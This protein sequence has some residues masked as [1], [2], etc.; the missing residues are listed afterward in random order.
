LPYKNCPTKSPAFTDGILFYRLK[1]KV[2][3][4]VLMEEK[5]HNH[6]KLVF[7]SNKLL[8]PN[9]PFLEV[10]MITASFPDK[11]KGIIII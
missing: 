6:I 11:Y 9:K 3:K 8:I 2:R 4:V 10:L 7:D 1:I 5:A